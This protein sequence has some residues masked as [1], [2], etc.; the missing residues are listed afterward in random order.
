MKKLL[1][2][3]LIAFSLLICNEL[4]AQE[5][6]KHV[7][8]KGETLTS[9]AA[10]YGVTVLEITTLNPKAQRFLFTG[11]ELQI[12]IK[13]K[14]AA[15]A[16]TGATAVNSTANAS[17][18]ATQQ[19]QVSSPTSG[20]KTDYTS[21]PE[22]TYTNNSTSTTN[23]TNQSST[24]VH[25]T[26]GY[27]LSLEEKAED[28]TVWGVSVLLSVDEYLTDIFY[29]GLGGGLTFGG[30][31]YEQDSYKSTSTAYQLAFPIYFGV[32]PIDGLDI[33]TGPSFN[34][35]VGGGTKLFVD[36]EKV[37]ESKYSDDKELKRFSPS[38]RIS[39]RLFN[40]LHV[41]VNIGLKKDSGASMTF[42]FSF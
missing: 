8:Q 30:S 22:S 25:F 15:P 34:W 20:T 7:V 4:S 36:G 24:S 16:S 29:V 26:A 40:C 37:S 38:W 14:P 12:P 42:G 9:I 11:M 3:I 33:D 10:N 41:G 39:A 1:T 27:N 28:S 18:P 17:V 35:L 32:T 31:K 6:V 19:A 5:T 21:Y 13:N 23:T 2:S